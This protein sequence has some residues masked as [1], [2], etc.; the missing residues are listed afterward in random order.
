VVKSPVAVK[1]IDKNEMKLL[2]LNWIDRKMKKVQE[3]EQRAIS[4]NGKIKRLLMDRDDLVQLIKKHWIGNG[5]IQDAAGFRGPLLLTSLDR[6]DS[7]GHYSKGNVRLLL[8]G[9]NLL[10]KQHDDA[11]LIDY[12]SHLRSRSANLSPAAFVSVPLYQTTQQLLVKSPEAR[13]EL[14]AV[15]KLEEQQEQEQE[16]EQ[17][18]E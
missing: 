13:E 7:R 3:N 4:S 8:L 10:K 17:E 16:Q 2:V 1:A 11:V 18:H 12:L 15:A 6:I 14:N 5:C 9:L